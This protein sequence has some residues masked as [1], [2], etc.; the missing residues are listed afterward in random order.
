MIDCLSCGSID[1]VAN[2]LKQWFYEMSSRS[3]NRK[4]YRIIGTELSED[5]KLLFITHTHTH[6]YTPIVPYVHLRT[7]TP[8]NTHTPPSGPSLNAD[9]D[10]KMSL[11][12]TYTSY[13]YLVSM[14][15]NNAIHAFQQIF[16]WPFTEW[17]LT[18]SPPRA[19][20]ILS[21][22]NREEI[23]GWTSSLINKSYRDV[24]VWLTIRLHCYLCN[25]TC[26][27]TYECVF[28][29]MRACSYAESWPKVRNHEI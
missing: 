15:K 17:F 14:V 26:L 27:Y 9:D 10:H 4:S 8:K 16:L 28:V 24:H 21:R 3:R 12:R 19:V 2:V 22:M 11:N 29:V 25:Y 6:T 20:W 18:R 5:V 23:V 1:W 7:P 13:V